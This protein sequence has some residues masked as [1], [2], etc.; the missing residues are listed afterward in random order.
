MEGSC[1]PIQNTNLYYNANSMYGDMP[2]SIT[3]ARSTEGGISYSD[4]ADC[5]S[6]LKIWNNLVI[7]QI[8]TKTPTIFFIFM[9]SFLSLSFL[10]RTTQS[11]DFIYMAIRFNIPGWHFEFNAR[12]LLPLRTVA[13]LWY[14]TSSWTARISG[15]RRYVASSIEMQLHGSRNVFGLWPKSYVSIHT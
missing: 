14:S 3:K 8:A 10:C 6:W 12:Q 2:Y 4:V 11:S 1:V 15:S 13:V 9:R 7:T 5:R